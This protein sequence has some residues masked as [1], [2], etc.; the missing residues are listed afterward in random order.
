[1]KIVVA[2][3]ISESAL[4]AFKLQ[5]TWQIVYLPGTPAGGNS[6]DGAIGE[7]DALIV[8]GATKVRAELLDR[9]PRLRAIGRAGVG[10]DNVDVDAA[11]K[12]GI[13]V[14][15]TPGGNA[16]SVAEHTLALILAL[17]RRLPQ[18]DSLLKQGAW[19]KK[20]LLGV[21]LRSKTLGLI[22]LGKI[23][24]EVARLA[25]AFAM[26]VLAYDPYVS[27]VLAGEQNVKL[28]PL[29][30]VLKKSDFVS[31]HASLTPETHHLVNTR[32]LALTKP[33]VRIINCAR[34]ELIHEGDL[35]RALESRHVAGA[36]LDVFETEPPQDL[37][38][39]SHPSVIATP[40]IAG[41]TEEAQ[42]IVGVRIAEQV[43]DYL[44]QGVARNAV[45]M[46]SLSTEEY[47]R[48]SPYLQLGEKLGAF[49]AQ[50]AGERLQ[51]VRI[52]YDGGLAELNTH[53]VKNAV[54][55][56]ILNQVLSEEANLINAGA[57][58]QE[59]GVEIVELRSARRADFL[60]SLGIA[61]RTET[62]ACSALG[63][64][65][66]RGALRILGINNIDVE[67]PLKGLILYIRNR[68]VPGV[69][70][71]VGTLLGDRKVNIANFALGRNQQA[72]EAIGLV[73]VDDRV[74]A[75]VLNE[76]RAIPA[77][78]VAR[79]VEV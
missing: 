14:M 4:E 64:V 32:T 49:L 24:I 2:D 56:G 40:H 67:A 34:G 57:L 13:V 68:D 17:A 50:I 42:E 15:N 37:R 58:A 35:L 30:E 71:R 9:A 22:G 55:K 73:N 66:L 72:E 31:L 70:G 16:V 29:D 27:S 39:A 59:R 47:K 28:A 62:E 21:E 36:G 18:A 77:V 46:P 26:D 19:E 10:V 76:I 25:Q 3:S 53:L 45:N 12:R 41:S 33:G 79:V 8:R 7:A 11:T 74:P 54:L 78:R 63:M 44:L 1:M 65:G 43:R 52:S 75:E 20:K 38:L 48:L 23:G 5:P 61:L 69:I 60:N 51:E 6:L